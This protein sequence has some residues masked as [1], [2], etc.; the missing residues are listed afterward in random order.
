MGMF[1]YLHCKMPLPPTEISPPSAVFQT[2]D[3]PD[4]EMTTYTISANGRL[5]RE[6]G[7][8]IDFHGN[9]DFYDGMNGG[10]WE[11]RARFTEGVC[12]SIRLLEYTPPSELTVNDNGGSAG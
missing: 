3:T 1:D 2:K 5:E 10:W 11:Y 4:Q 8:I 12:T 6:P 7:E 9:I